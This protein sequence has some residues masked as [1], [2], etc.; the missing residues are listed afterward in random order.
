MPNYRNL[1][2]KSLRDVLVFGSC[3]KIVNVSVKFD[4][5]S[6]DRKLFEVIEN[7]LPVVWAGSE[8]LFLYCSPPDFRRL[9]IPS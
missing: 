7:R 9:V 8:Q 2:K 1:L 4:D 3:E 5:D 6:P